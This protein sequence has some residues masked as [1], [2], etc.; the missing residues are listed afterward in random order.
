MPALAFPEEVRRNVAIQ[1]QLMDL[2]VDVLENECI[3]HN[4]P[5]TK[6]CSA[7]RKKPPGSPINRSTPRRQEME[8]PRHHPS[9]INK[10][11]VGPCDNEKK[12]KDAMLDMWIGHFCQERE[13]CFCEEQ[14]HLSKRSLRT[15]RTGLGKVIPGHQVNID[16]WELHTM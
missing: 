9:S 11:E 10:R 16:G 14:G 4:V 5:E 3:R 7:L 2:F 1:A 6:W 15:E 12:K 13:C 8:T